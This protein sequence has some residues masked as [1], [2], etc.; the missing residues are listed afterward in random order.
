MAA[1]A[2]T[3]GDC[4]WVVGQL[5]GLPAATC[6]KPHLFVVVAHIIGLIKH[7]DEAERALTPPNLTWK[8]GPPPGPTNS[9]SIILR[10]TQLR[11]PCSCFNFIVLHHSHIIV[12]R[13]Y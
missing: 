12:S 11:Q 1:V 9:S 4:R 3:N 13:V 7:P 5:Q 6:T 2:K 10:P 8:S